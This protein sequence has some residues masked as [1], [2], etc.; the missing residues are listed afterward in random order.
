[1]GALGSSSSCVGVYN[2]NASYSESSEYACMFP[3]YRIK[4]KKKMTGTAFLP[5]KRV[6][7]QYSSIPGRFARNLDCSKGSYLILP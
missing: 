2:R 5:F 6:I 4:K 3:V 1:M 7:G